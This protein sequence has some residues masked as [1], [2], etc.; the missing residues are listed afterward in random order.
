MRTVLILLLA[1]FSLI[2]YGQDFPKKSNRLVNDYA[3]VLTQDEA[4][5][6]ENLL[7]KYDN[8]T[9]VQITVVIM[10]TIDGYPIDDYAFELGEK[11][12][13]GQGDTDNGAVVVVSID[14]RKMWIATG[15]GLEATLPDAIVKR[16][17]Q[18]EITPQFKGGR[19]YHGL[20]AGADAM[21]LATKGE[22]EGQGNGGGGSSAAGKSIPLVLLIAGIWLIVMVT[23]SM[24][25]RRH[26][27]LN[28]LSFWA[29]W[30]L[31]NSASRR[32][33]GS[34]SSFRGGSGGFGSGGGF[35]GFG[36]G[37][38]GGGGAGGSW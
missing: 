21:I 19:Y 38:F 35:G 22:Y 26:A 6:F 9:S 20:K 10:S 34:Y 8:E 23:K 7:V 11:W 25:V 33:G 32:H 16:I 14:E 30:M 18:N 28:G 3:K 15:Y 36:G 4:N 24:Q 27:R 12:G 1:G 2:S 17:I 5:D 31:L 37:S 13:V 29:A